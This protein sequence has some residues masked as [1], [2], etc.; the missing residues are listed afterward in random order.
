MAGL[1]RVYIDFE[2]TAS[3]TRIGLTMRGHKKQL[4]VMSGRM[5]NELSQLSTINVTRYLNE[6]ASDIT[7]YK[8]FTSSNDNDNESDS[9]STTSSAFKALTTVLITEFAT[10]EG[11][12]ANFNWATALTANM[13]SRGHYAKFNTSI[14]PTVRRQKIEYYHRDVYGTET[15]LGSD[16]TVNFDTDE[17][18]LD[19]NEEF[20]PTSGS[21]HDIGDRMVLKFYAQFENGFMEE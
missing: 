8:T 16:I 21:F 4:I 19:V 11:N 12:L 20:Y 14:N 17:S 9:A 2:S 3:T 10:D 7:D 6:A 5:Q 1:W 13:K 15:L 18:E